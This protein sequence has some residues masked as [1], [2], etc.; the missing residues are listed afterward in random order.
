MHVVMSCDQIV[1]IFKTNSQ[2]ILFIKAME[3]WAAIET[4]FLK[5]SHP[6]RRPRIKDQIDDKTTI[7]GNKSVESGTDLLQNVLD[8]MFDIKYGLHAI[9]IQ[10][11]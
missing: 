11:F 9:I 10:Y 5:Y 4:D 1:I 8:S 2:N 7:N 3:E 6:K